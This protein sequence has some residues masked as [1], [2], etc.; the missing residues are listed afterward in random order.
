[1]LYPTKAPRWI[2]WL[3]R[4]VCAHPG[5]LCSETAI[6]FIYL[7][8][9]YPACPAK[10]KKSDDSTC[11]SHRF[12]FLSRKGKASGFLGN[13]SPGGDVLF[14][15]PKENQKSASDFDALDPRTRGCSPL[16]T[17]KKKSKRKNAS[18]FAK[19]IFHASPID[20][21]LSRCGGSSLQG[22]RVRPLSFAQQL[23][24]R[25]SQETFPLRPWLPLRERRPRAG[26]GGTKCQK[27]NSWHRKAVTERVC[28]PRWRECS[29]REPAT[30]YA[31]NLYD[32]SCEKAN[33]E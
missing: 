9:I 2:H 28:F 23:S 22:E 10:G 16:V 8:I 27:G 33:Q 13:A 4:A 18:R 3:L 1:M 29:R 17:P 32:P 30:A 15:R 26:G 5:H 11:T 19:S 14:C 24:Q 25:E 12:F 6:F 7:L 21:P 31:V 20:R